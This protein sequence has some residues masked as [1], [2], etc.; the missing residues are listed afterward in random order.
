MELLLRLLRSGQITRRLTHFSALRLRQP[1]HLQMVLPLRMALQPREQRLEMRA[2]LEGQQQTPLRGLCMQTY[3]KGGGAGTGGAGTVP[4][5]LR[6]QQ[7]AAQP[8]RLGFGVD[9]KAQHHM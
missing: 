3:Q 6:Q 2:S 8:Y 7:T 9:R 1:L 5:A 4:Y